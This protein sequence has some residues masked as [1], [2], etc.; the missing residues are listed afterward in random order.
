MVSA[1]TAFGML[2]RNV[3]ESGC[4]RTVGPSLLRLSGA[5]M[6]KVETTRDDGWT[7]WDIQ[8]APESMRDEDAQQRIA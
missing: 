7:C 8:S 4:I 6:Q 1:A 3:R 5:S 2:L